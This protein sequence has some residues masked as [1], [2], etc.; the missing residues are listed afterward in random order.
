MGVRRMA[1]DSNGRLVAQIVIGAIMAVL[2]FVGLFGRLWYGAVVAL[3]AGIW[4]AVASGIALRRRSSA[5]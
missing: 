5:R 3:I 4:L 2:G 1:T